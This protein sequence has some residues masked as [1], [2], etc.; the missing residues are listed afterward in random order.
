MR[1]F[2]AL[3]ASPSPALAR[4]GPS[5]SPLK[6][7][8]GLSTVNLR[9]RNTARVQSLSLPRTALLKS[10]SLGYRAGIRPWI[11]AFA[12]M[13]EECR[14]HVRSGSGAAPSRSC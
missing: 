4:R 2:A 7:G 13:T 5:L 1:Q 6:G 3:P 14:G 11:P 12:G 10:G 8:E 9:L